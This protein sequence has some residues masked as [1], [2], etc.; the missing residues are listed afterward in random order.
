MAER[1]NQEIAGETAIL[2]IFLRLPR[3]SVKASFSLCPDAIIIDLMLFRL[4]PS[5]R[6]ACGDD[7]LPGR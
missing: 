6:T 5:R 4:D 1:P 3:D 2:A 7:A